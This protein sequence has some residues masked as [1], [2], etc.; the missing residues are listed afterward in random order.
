MS[1]QHALNLFKDAAALCAEL[2]AEYDESHGLNHH[3]AV[4]SNVAAILDHDDGIYLRTLCHLAALLHDV[5]DHKYPATLERNTAALEKF[6]LDA[7]GQDDSVK[8]MWIIDN[9]SYSKEAKFGRPRNENRYVQRA[10][11]IVS[12]A[13]KIEALGPDGIKRCFTFQRTQNITAPDSVIHMSVIKQCR[14]KFIRYRDEFII[15]DEGKR[16]AT[17][18]HDYIAGYLAGVDLAGHI[19]GH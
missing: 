2:T 12:D 11:D 8:I 16:L 18:G 10:R 3:L 17:R 4:N 7:V 19:A 13:D 9:I 15:T 5:V 6:L 14:E 1:Y